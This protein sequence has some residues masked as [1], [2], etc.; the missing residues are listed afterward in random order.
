M[1]TNAPLVERSGVDCTPLMP[2]RRTMP[3]HAPNCG[4]RMTSSIT[5]DWRLRNAGAVTDVSEK[6]THSKK[7]KN[8]EP[9]LP[10]AKG[11]RLHIGADVGPAPPRRYPN[12]VS[13]SQPAERPNGQTWS[14]LK[15]KASMLSL[16]LMLLPLP[17]LCM[18]SL[19]ALPWT[20]EQ[21]L[22]SCKLGPSRSRV[23][24][25]GAQT[26]SARGTAS[27]SQ[28]RSRAAVTVGHVR[29]TVERYSAAAD[30]ICAMERSRPCR[31]TTGIT[32]S[33]RNDRQ[34]PPPASSRRERR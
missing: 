13:R 19:R 23:T 3:Q 27:I 18:L 28:S 33:G 11:D 24:S 21:P 17:R 7:F 14:G 34:S 22:S 30:C 9:T 15:Q 2:A 12:C 26:V 25:P 29:S 1:P 20:G 31:P 32:P 8:S 6:L 10:Q 5:I 4:S 16:V